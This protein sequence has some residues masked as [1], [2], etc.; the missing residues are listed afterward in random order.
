M[1]KNFMN[2]HFNAPNVM[3]FN[4]DQRI[5]D[6]LTK[7]VS[8]PII[9]DDF[10]FVRPDW[11]GNI[12]WVCGC[13]FKS[14][15][16]FNDLFEELLILD[17]MQTL[18]NHIDF[19]NRIIMY[20]GFFVV[21]SE[22]QTPNFH[23]DWA[24]NCNNNA[25]TLITPVIHPGDGLN[26][27]YKDNEGINRKYNYE[28]GSCIT[29]GSKFGHSTDVGVSSSPSILL[30]MTF[31]TDLMQHWE[32]IAQTAATQSKVYRLRNGNFFHKDFN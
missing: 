15:K 27:L 13:S 8:S 9:S 12:H 29:F 18:I 16:I 19:N 22:C 26:L 20:S 24:A 11:S 1:G 25:F 7:L 2:Q 32:A 23:H 14:Y 10:S 30:S 3:E 31:G 28:L 4:F 6:K 5:L 21:R 17:D